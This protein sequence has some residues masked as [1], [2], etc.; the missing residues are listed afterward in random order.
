MLH[1]GLEFGDIIRHCRDILASKPNYMVVLCG[2]SVTKLL[3]CWLGNLGYLSLL[4]YI[5]VTPPSFPLS[6]LIDVCF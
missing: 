4:N 6:S 5:R 1:D 3:I 2:G